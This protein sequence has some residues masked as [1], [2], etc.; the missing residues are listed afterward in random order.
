[1]VSMSQGNFPIVKSVALPL[2]NPKDLSLRAIEAITEAEFVYCEDKR[3]FKALTSQLEIELRPTLSMRTI[4]GNEE[5]NEDWSKL[6]KEAAGK[7]VL[8]VSDAG[9]PIINDPGKALT[10]FAKQEGWGFE[11]I[12]G[13][14]APIFAIQLTG[15]FGLPFSFFGFA[16]K[17][18]GAESKSFKAFVQRIDESKTFIFF[19]TRYQIV[20][21]LENLVSLGLGDRNMF[22][23]REQTKTHEEIISASVSET[24]K[25]VVDKLKADDAIGELTLIIEGNPDVVDGSKSPMGTEALLEFRNAAPR[26]AAKILSGVSGLSSQESYK[27]II[28]SRD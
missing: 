16:P 21:T 14:S 27:L 17:G 1:M 12:P 11:A 22:L 20:N 4:P 25:W 8:L 26:K 28:E 15:G 6:S 24:L 3:K 23:T 19:D 7:T 18:K 9:T 5:W 10:L 13:P 2:G